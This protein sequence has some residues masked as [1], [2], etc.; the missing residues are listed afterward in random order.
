E[1]K[2][3]E[4][5]PQI[6]SQRKQLAQEWSQGGALEG[7]KGATALVMNPT[8]I[9]VSLMFDA[10]ESALPYIGPKGYDE[11]ALEM[12]E[13]AEEEGIP[14]LENIP[15]A[16]DLDARCQKGDP[17]PADLFDTIA[18]IIVW[19]QSK[20]EETVDGAASGHG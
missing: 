3:A 19:A 10:A 8:H 2:D 14:I 16:R 6:K 9:A 15:L 20:R 4:G 18:E 13:R 17:I 12:R 7:L 1:Q 11:L 5:D